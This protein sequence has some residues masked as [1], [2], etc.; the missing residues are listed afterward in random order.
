MPKIKAILFDLGKVLLFFNFDS[1]FK[2]FAKHG[3]GTPKD[4]ENYFIQS[5]IEVLYDGGKITSFQFY[6]RIKKALGLRLSF[7]QFKRIWNDIFTPN[8]PMITL[9]GKLSVRY[10][11]VLISNTNAMHYEHV[12][13]KYAFMKNFDRHILSYQERS[14]KPDDR[15]YSIASKAC[16]A[17]PHEIFYIDDRHDLTDA[18]KD[19]GFN[20][21]TY[22]NNHDHLL[23]LIR[24]MKIL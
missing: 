14:R 19:L 4:I 20:V 1:A 7:N 5:G 3:G 24:E 12:K 22:R 10:R 2:R 6:S 15:I 11:T 9:L 8:R 16:R 23:Q 18:A 21:F 17:K 13:N